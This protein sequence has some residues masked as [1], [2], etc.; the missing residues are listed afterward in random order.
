MT[1]RPRSTLD[2]LQSRDPAFLQWANQLGELFDLHAKGVAITFGD[3]GALA[4]NKRRVTIKVVDRLTRDWGG[5]SHLRL[6]V[7][8]NALGGPGGT[9]TVTVVTGTTV[10]AAVA[11]QVVDVVTD[12]D[13][14]VV[15]DIEVSGSG[16][17][18]VAAHIA[19]FVYVS[20]EMTWV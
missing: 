19:G 9:Q 7:G 8:N 13:G 20:E 10:A 17:R 12:N 4:A 1:T 16:S 2:E 6:V 14:V 3:E 11:N 5:I 18:W 15:I